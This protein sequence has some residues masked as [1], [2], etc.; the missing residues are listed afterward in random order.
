MN[1]IKLFVAVIVLMISLQGCLTT[2]SWIMTGTMITV[3]LIS[4]A[5]ISGADEK[6]DDK[7]AKDN[8]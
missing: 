2:A 4:K 1:K 6:L 3:D 8:G 7:E 5:D